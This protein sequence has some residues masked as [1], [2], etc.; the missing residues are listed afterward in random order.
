[1]QAKSARQLLS[2]FLEFTE[3]EVL[4]AFASL[5]RAQ[6]HKGKEFVYIPGTRKDR[7]L[8]VAHADTVNDEKYTPKLRWMGD[9]CT[10]EKFW[11]DSEKRVYTPGH[12]TGHW[13]TS[14]LGADDRAGCA[15]LWALQNTGHSLLITTGEE[16]GCKGARTAA[17]ELK[18]ELP[19]HAYALEIDRRGDRQAVFYDISTQAFEAYMLGLLNKHDPEG[20]EWYQ[21]LGSFTDVRAICP[22]AQICGVNLSAGYV[23]EHSS[24]EHLYL[25]AWLHTHGTLAAMLK[26]EQT[27]Y[28]L[29]KKVATVYK[30]PTPP[31]LSGHPARF[32]WCYVH[33]GWG[34]VCPISMN[35]NCTRVQAEDAKSSTDPTKKGSTSTESPFKLQVFR[36]PGGS[37][38]GEGRVELRAVAV[39]GSTVAPAVVSRISKR[40]C[41]KFGKYLQGL[42]GKGAVTNAEATSLLAQAIAFRDGIRAVVTKEQ[43]EEHAAGQTDAFVKGMLESGK[44]S[45]VPTKTDSQIGNRGGE[46]VAYLHKAGGRCWHHCRSCQNLWYHEREDNSEDRPTFFCYCPTCSPNVVPRLIAPTDYTAATWGYASVEKPAPLDA[47]AAMRAVPHHNPRNEPSGKG[48]SQALNQPT[49]CQHYCY[50]CVA[51][52][53]HMRTP[54]TRSSVLCAVGGYD[55]ECPLHSADAA[56]TVFMYE[57]KLNI[58]VGGWRQTMHAPPLEEKPATGTGSHGAAATEGKDLLPLGA[59]GTS[60]EATSGGGGVAH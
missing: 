14:S 26:E 8:L 41:K 51:S 25:E 34:D 5:A 4:G 16:S 35:L 45:N 32:K 56:K 37:K 43:R 59:L 39:G 38:P 13:G 21:E 20:V 29:P 11:R 55:H 1:M 60:Q 23:R 30:Q 36:I 40:Q 12:N 57:E 50:R 15:M 6:E 3:T 10:L 28:A 19:Q 42:M 9:V 44:K 54:F 22:E 33:G 49:Q 18:K 48:E 52:W 47:V 7:I 27:A 58:L 24:D 31:T 2:R 46:F 53:K 17:R